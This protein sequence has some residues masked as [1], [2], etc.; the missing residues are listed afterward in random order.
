MQ[1]CIDWLVENR[2]NFIDNSVA[3][4]R[5]LSKFYVFYTYSM[6][7]YAHDRAFFRLS[8]LIV[9]RVQPRRDEKCE[10]LMKYSPALLC[11]LLY[12]RSLVSFEQVTSL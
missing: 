3:A 5:S 10:Q 2:P 9:A 7:G 8:L 4:V 6:H 1:N 12:F 11:A